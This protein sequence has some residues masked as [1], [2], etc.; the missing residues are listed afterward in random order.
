MIDK[1]DI[2]VIICAAGMGMRLGIGVTKTLLKLDGKSL[3][4]L[5]LEQLQSFDDIR[6]VVGFQA[7]KV[8]DEV[9]KI[10]KDVMYVFNYDYKNTGPA[11]SVSRALFKAR[12]YI[13]VLDGDLLIDPN[14]FKMFLNYDEEC[15]CVSKQKSSEPIG[16]EVVDNCVVS[17]N[18]EQFQYEWIGVA[19]IRADKLL[20]NKF[21][22]YDM[23]APS[24][25]LN[26]FEIKA[27][28]IDTA[29]DYESAANWIKNNYVG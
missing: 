6:I 11:E 22:I 19:K 20:K 12:E 7:E 29:E 25:P 1:K 2:T 3:I 10:R 26:K 17:F 14:S 23:I 8:I 27:I 24:L 4:A 13:I 28:D 5:Q 21:A 16:V 18:N 9:N 15:I